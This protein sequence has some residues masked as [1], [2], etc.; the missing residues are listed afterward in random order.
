[1]SQMFDFCSQVKF[2]E[3]NNGYFEEMLEFEENICIHYRFYPNGCSI[4]LVLCFILFSEPNYPSPEL[5]RG[6]VLLAE[7]AE[8]LDVGNLKGGLPAGSRI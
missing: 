8:I 7:H 6:A 5:F 1:M 4:F 2:E 3:A